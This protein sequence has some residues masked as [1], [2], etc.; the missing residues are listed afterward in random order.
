M[1]QLIDATRVE[2]EAGEPRCAAPHAGPDDERRRRRASRA[3]LGLGT[4]FTGSINTACQT[5]PPLVEA[6]GIPA[7]SMAHRTF[8]IGYPAE[9]YQRVPARKPV[10]AIWD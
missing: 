6:L 7:G 5:Y 9:K 2:T 10:D 3:A 8:V 4:T 1:R